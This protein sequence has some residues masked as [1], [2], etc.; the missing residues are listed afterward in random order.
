[1]MRKTKKWSV[2]TGYGIPMKTGFNFFDQKILY[3]RTGLSATKY[4]KL[5]GSIN[6]GKRV[7][8]DPYDKPSVYFS[9]FDLTDDDLGGPDGPNKL[10]LGPIRSIKGPMGFVSPSSITGSTIHFESVIVP[11][12]L[13]KEDLNKEPFLFNVWHEAQSSLYTANDIFIIGY[14]FLPTDYMTE[15]MIRQG[16][17]SGF[18]RIR[19][20][21]RRIWCINKSIESEYCERVSTIF[22]NCNIAFIELDTVSFLKQWLVN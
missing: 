2:V 16:L 20:E 5:H 11:P 17:S 12:I 4:L 19:K 21:P 1:M 9:V 13:N 14:S 6:W 18:E 22:K 3:N 10:P 7:I 8:E 15:F